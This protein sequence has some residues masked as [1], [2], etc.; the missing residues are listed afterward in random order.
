ME[1]ALPL[2]IGAFAL[3]SLCLAPVARS[4][5]AFFRGTIP[6][7][8]GPSVFTLTLSLV[9][10]WIF[11]RSLLNAAILGFYFGPWGTVAYAAYYLS[12]VTGALVVDQVRFR[13]G[14]TS[15]QAFL[16]ERFGR[17][18]RFAY[19]LVV[20]I[21]LLSEVFANLLVIGILFGEV[22]SGAWGWSMVG[23]AAVALIYSAMGGL[24]ASLRTDVIQMLLFL[25]TLVAVMIGMV[26]MPGFSPGQLVANA[27]TI[28]DPGP[29]LLLVAL[30]Q[31]ISYPVHDPVMMD[32]GFIADRKTT[33]RAFLHAAWVSG[34]CILAFGSLGV[35]AA[36]AAA[37]GEDMMTALERMLG[38]PIA[39]MLTLGLAISAMS[40][41]DSTLSS[42]ARMVVDEVPGVPATRTVGRVIMV[43]A[44]ILGLGLVFVGSKDLFD[45]VAASGTAAMYL[46]PIVLFS[47]LLNWRVPAWSAMVALVAAVAGAALYVFEAN[48][49]SSWLKDL[50]GLGHKYSLLLV[51][52]LA[53]AAIGCAA[54][55]I[56]RLIT[57]QPQADVESETEPETK[58][59]AT[60]A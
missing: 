35:V 28:S 55:V 27:G 37:E 8:S 20:G 59:E 38:A 34:I 15:I 42:T 53:V 30:V 13:H 26:L 10:T 58:P 11:A 24:Q 29:V 44:T 41:L 51:I 12:F 49:T 21:R 19:N 40:T 31:V 32:R 9:T 6:G 33:L 22:G 45:A 1:L 14:S 7:T 56:G 54:F 4:D 36:T 52:S 3:L 17:S 18:G 48:G 2:T 39:L 57:P 25:V 46:L 5:H 47:V 60:P 16:G 50:T 23:F 43:I